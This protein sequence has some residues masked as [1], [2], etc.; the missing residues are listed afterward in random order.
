MALTGV[1]GLKCCNASDGRNTPLP[2]GKSGQWRPG[3]DLDGHCN[4]VTLLQLSS[5]SDERSLV[6]TGPVLFQ[7]ACARV[8]PLRALLCWAAAVYPPLPT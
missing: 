5:A 1:K 3:G 4:Q 6:L 8:S 7:P 2:D